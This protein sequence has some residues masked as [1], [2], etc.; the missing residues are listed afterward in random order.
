MNIG[1]DNSNKTS[2]WPADFGGA[3]RP[4]SNGS[5]LPFRAGKNFYLSDCTVTDY[6]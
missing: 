5:S 3:A 2:F 1:E 4:A 6:T